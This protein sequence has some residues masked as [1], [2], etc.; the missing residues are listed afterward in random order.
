MWRIIAT[1]LFLLFSVAAAAENHPLQKSS[2]WDHT[3]TCVVNPRWMT[4]GKFWFMVYGCGYPYSQYKK[5]E[6]PT[7]VDC[8][9]IYPPLDM[10]GGVYAIQR[11]EPKNPNE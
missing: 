9:D 11:C 3:H 1:V 7:D 6:E 4:D 2:F 5:A 8:Q 10:G